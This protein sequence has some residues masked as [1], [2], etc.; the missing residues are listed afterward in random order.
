MY[1]LLTFQGYFLK[2]T[3]AAT[4]LFLGIMPVF[5]KIK[6]PVNTDYLLP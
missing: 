2:E 6:C 4:H 5:K 1:P 3:G